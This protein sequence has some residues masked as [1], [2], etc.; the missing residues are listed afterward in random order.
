MESL[1]AVIAA[2]VGCRVGCKVEDICGAVAAALEKT[3]KDVEDIFAIYAPAFKVKEVSL[4]IAARKL[5]K[6]LILL[7]TEEVKAQN[8][9]TLSSSEHVWRY[10]GVASVSEAVALAGAFSVLRSSSAVRLL[11]PRSI[12][13]GATCALAI[14]EDQI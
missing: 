1:Q 10:F 12:V 14:E 5:G 13:G 2:G 11:G 9:G 7:R 8:A 4:R 6:Q 3:G